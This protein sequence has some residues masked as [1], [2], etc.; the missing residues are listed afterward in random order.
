MTEKLY[1]KSPY[2][3][4]AEAEVVEVVELDGAVEVV[5]NRTPFYPE[6]GGQPCDF[7]TI[8]GIA[9]EHVE[10][11]EDRI[12]HRMKVCPEGDKVVCRIDP[13]RREDHTQQH[14]GEHL[15]SAAFFKLYGASNAGFHLG[16]DYVTVDVEIK[17]MTQ[18][19]LRD[20]ER[21][22]N[23]YVMENQKVKTYF[24]D[25]T[26]AE[27]LPLRK[28]IKAEGGI[29]I[30]QMGES[31]DY[32]ACCGTH[33]MFTGEV[34][35]IKIIKAEKYKGMTRVYM[36]A[37]YRAYEDYRL[38]QEIVTSLSQG[39]SCET[40]ELLSRVKRLKEDLDAARSMLSAYKTKAAQIEAEQLLE[41]LKETPGR[42][43]VRIYENESFEFLEK[44][45][46]KL[47]DQDAILLLGSLPDQ[48]L[49]LGDP[50]GQEVDCGKLF[51]ENLKS[52]CGRGGGNAKRAQAGFD[53][54]EDLLKFKEFICNK[55]S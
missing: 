38:M 18:E 32:S 12:Y 50:E 10:E 4:E 28:S 36:K 17:D 30:V 37:G 45:Y 1:Y 33:V 55:L 24:L 49:L 48:K 35:M 9:V 7:G 42:M 5:L 21:E 22:A 25:R 14:S 31:L 39:F 11:R 15:L 41:D 29:R 6:G 13:V 19:M 20:A 44:L 40:A 46:D 26:E 53:H 16:V 43:I 8:N 34:G 27:K 47:K 3:T 52:Y 51:K 23:S 54:I 2:L